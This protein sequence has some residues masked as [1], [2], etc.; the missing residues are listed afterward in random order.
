[1]KRDIFIKKAIEIHGESYDYSLIP[2]EFKTKDKLP[3]I[4]PKHGIFYKDASHHIYSK[5]GCPECMG[6]KRRSEDEFIA[7]AKTLPNVSELSFENT[8]YCNNKTKVKI[9]CHHKDD[10][11]NEHG[12][13]E[14]SPGHFFSGER[15]P[16]CRYIKSA[17][18]KRRSLEDVIREAKKVHGEKYDY[19]LISEY[20]NDRIKYPII[21]SEHGVF[22][23][24]MNNHIKLKQGCPTCGRIK[25]DAERR[26]TF[27]EFTE[28]ANLVHGSKYTYD[29]SSYLSASDYITIICPKHGEFKHLGT[30][31]IHLGHGCPKCASYGSKSETELYE[32]LCSIV[33]KEKVIEKKRG[34]INGNKELDIYIPSKKFAV[35]FNGLYWHCE[36]S[37]DKNYH[38]NKTKECED[39]GIRLFHVFE[40][41]WRDK[42]NIVKSM[43]NNILV[44]KSERIFA[45]KCE[46][47]D[48]STDEAKKFLNENHLQ[49]YC[50]A[51]IRYGL[52]YNGILMSLMTFGKTRHFVGNG[53]H[54][55]ELLRFCNRLNYSVVGGASKLLN[56]FIQNINPNEIISY[57]DRRWSNGNLYDKLGFSLY[58]TSKPNYYYIIGGKRIYRYNLR[59]GVLMK[60]YGCPENMTEREFCLSQKWYRIYDCGCLCYVW[61]K[62]K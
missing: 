44:E 48:V 54:E 11:G 31:H 24:T 18:A 39:N 57:A 17:N 43:L 30:N 22:Y 50:P 6:R 47:H 32:Y 34:A 62:E 4:C 27:S 52:Y 40:D 56:Y 23:Q 41:E 21:C 45:R 13:F 1:M 53:K 55:W 14:I 19:S 60:K 26:M 33:G 42:K 29:E 51:K 2:E 12:E 46:I 61:K 10:N 35:E 28:I 5:Q 20:K 58:N 36:L 9:F 25:C 8:H 15:C 59:K 38:L 37:K 16:K 7:K 49:G 3:I